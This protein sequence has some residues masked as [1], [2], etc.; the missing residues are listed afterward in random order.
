MVDIITKI[1]V[2]QAVVSNSHQLTIAS[3]SNN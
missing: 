2:G 1:S 3:E